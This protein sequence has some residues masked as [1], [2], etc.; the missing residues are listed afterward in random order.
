MA[1]LRIASTLLARASTG[2]IPAPQAVASRKRTCG[3]RTRTASDNSQPFMP[4]PCPCQTPPKSRRSPGRAWSTIW[5]AW[6]S[7]Q[8]YGPSQ[9]ALRKENSQ[10]DDP[11]FA[12][13][14]SRR[15]FH[16]DGPESHRVPDSSPFWRSLVALSTG[17]HR[18]AMARRTRGSARSRASRTC[19]RLC[20]F[21]CAVEGCGPARRPVETLKHPRHCA[22]RRVVSRT[23]GSCDHHSNHTDTD[24]ALSVLLANPTITFPA[25]DKV[26]GN[27]FGGFSAGDS[28]RYLLPSLS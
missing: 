19:W 25:T 18:A 26:I 14:R 28:N 12:R 5:A 4:R 3:Q 20:C 13:R 21:A 15:A 11:R 16:A 9:D 23:D 7:P 8:P 22:I 1:L 17:L 2:S 27:L 6:V 10:R 24:E